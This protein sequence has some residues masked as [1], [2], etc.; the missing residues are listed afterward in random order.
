MTAVS[1]L[2][3]RPASG[4]RVPLPLDVRLLVAS[5]ACAGFGYVLTA[6][7]D[8]GGSRTF[9]DVNVRAGAQMHINL[10]DLCK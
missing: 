3:L 6:T 7:Y 1:L 10:P 4:E 9:I 5:Y 2:P 8:D